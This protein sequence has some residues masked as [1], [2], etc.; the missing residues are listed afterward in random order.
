M[1]LTVPDEHELTSAQLVNDRTE[2]LGLMAFHRDSSQHWDQHLF[3]RQIFHD[4]MLQL[5]HTNTNREQEA[6]STLQYDHAER[7]SVKV[8][9]Y[10]PSVK[11]FESVSNC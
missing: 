11:K 2:Q 10:P 6:L 4:L 5:K 9:R 8:F 7:H 3:V 1:A